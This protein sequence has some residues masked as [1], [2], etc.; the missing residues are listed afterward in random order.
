MLRLQQGGKV[1][2]G[3]AL[4]DGRIVTGALAILLGIALVDLV[5]LV[6]TF[7]WLDAEARLKP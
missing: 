2:H 6:L 5:L 7:R 1:C 3:K 4:R